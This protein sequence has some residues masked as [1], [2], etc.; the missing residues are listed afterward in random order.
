MFSSFSSVNVSHNVKIPP[1]ADPL[2]EPGAGECA[3]WVV[4]TLQA[5]I[6]ANEPDAPAHHFP[7]VNGMNSTISPGTPKTAA[8]K[9]D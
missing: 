7:L 5:R 8:M 4:E 3:S 6:R 2:I 1:L 9:R